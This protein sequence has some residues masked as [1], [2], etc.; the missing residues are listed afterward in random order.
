MSHTTGTYIT[1]PNLAAYAD[2]AVERAGL[3]LQEIT[4]Q[5]LIS[6]RRS[7]GFVLSRWSNKGHR[8]WTFQQVS[9]TTAIGENVFNLPTG[10]IDVQTVVIRRNGVDTEMYPISRSDYLIIHDKTLIGR[11]DRYFI[12]RRR[13]IIEPGDTELVQ[14]FYWLS[15]ENTTDQIIVNVYKQIEDPGN[16]QNALDIPFRFQEA[17]A[18]AMAAKIAQKYKPERFVALMTES[19][20]LFKEAD[21]EDHESAPMVISVNYDRFYGRR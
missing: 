5:H 16:A 9:H 17:F 3:D 21:D 6:I 7:A 2:E 1:D 4:A 11:P 10:T 15:G 20:V 12:D 14:M 18:A 8:Q 13:G 19:E